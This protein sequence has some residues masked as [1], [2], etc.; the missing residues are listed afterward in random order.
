[1]THISDSETGTNPTRITRIYQAIDAS[2]N[3]ARCTQTITVQGLAGRF[4]LDGDCAVDRA[5]LDLLL[6]HIRQHSGDPWYDLNGDGKVDIADARCLVLH[7]TA[8]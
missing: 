7:F 5:D 1:M 4:D 6:A 2:G 3:S 8:Q